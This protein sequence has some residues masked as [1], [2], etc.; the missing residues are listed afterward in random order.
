M[1]THVDRR[2]FLTRAALGTA[3]TVVGA[4][5]LGS[6]APQAAFGATDARVVPG[7]PDPNFA[8]GRI[9]GIDG[10]LIRATGSDGALHRIYATSA[11]SVWKLTPTTFDTVKVGDG[12]YAR[13]V[14]LPDGSLAA[15]AIWANIVSL[16]ASVVDL[17]RNTIHLDHKGSRIVGNI[18]QGTS[19]AVYNGTPAVTDL[20]MVQVGRHVHIIGAWRP[21][22]NETDI[23]TL[24]TA[25]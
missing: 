5:A 9:S 19:A 10:S 7:T 3:T 4:T 22:T 13:G 15:D 20:S 6:L 14:R 2:Q 23:A 25:V 24:Y 18:I 12:L 8:E 17:S 21:D 11:T 1:T 16:D